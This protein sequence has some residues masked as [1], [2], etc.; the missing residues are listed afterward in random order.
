MSTDQ[1]R[2]RRA[3]TT[4]TAPEYRHELREDVEDGQPCEALGGRPDDEA[5]LTAEDARLYVSVGALLNYIA[6]D[7]PDL[8]Y[9]VKEAMRRAADP[10]VG[11]LKR[12][13]RIGRFIVGAPRRAIAFPW[14]R[15]ASNIVE[16]LVDSDFAGCPRTRRSTAGGAVFFG[17][18]C[19]KTW[20]KPLSVLA[21]SSGEAE[22]MAVVKG[23]Q[24]G[25]GM[26]A[27]LADWGIEA[28]IHEKSDAT[29]AIGI[30]ARTGPGKVRHLAVA[31]LWVQGA[32]RRGEIEFTKVPGAI[33]PA[34]LMTKALDRPV[35]DRHC[36]TLGLISLEVARG[37]VCGSLCVDHF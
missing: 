2:Q 6:P 37:E 3:P 35:C 20:A 11:Y 15:D 22:L 27:L 21:L 7:R 16:V 31:D 14:S 10:T 5:P 19:I 24:E 36:A 17:G 1:I 33:N 12:L 26:K 34:D 9:A 30:V 29:A 28:R 23:A 4:E 25:L 32:A 18:H 8:Q 13:K